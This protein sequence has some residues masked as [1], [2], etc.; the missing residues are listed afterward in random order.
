MDTLDPEAF[1]HFKEIPCDK[2]GSVS[3][4]SPEIAAKVTECFGCQCKRLE[5]MEIA[6]VCGWKGNY[7]QQ[8]ATDDLR[9]RLCP[10]CNKPGYQEMTSPLSDFP[11]H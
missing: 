2:C 6:C 7:F 1:N 8:N 11:A 9:G 10:D 4:Y 3:S 5:K